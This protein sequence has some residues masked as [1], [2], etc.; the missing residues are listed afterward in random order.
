MDLADVL[1]T[2]EEAFPYIDKPARVQIPFHNDTCFHCE[3]ILKMLDEH[4]GRELPATAIACL[5]DDMSALSAKGTQWVLPSYLRIALRSKD[6]HDR[7]PEFLIYTLG[8]TEEYAQ[9]TRL[10]L[11]LLNTSQ[12]NCLLTVLLYWQG[13]PHWDEYC[14]QDLVNAITFIRNLISSEPLRTPN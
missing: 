6:P 7:I 2:V 8:Q 13:H 14:P 10:Q 9:E 11:A 4:P 3:A 12:L 5:C 1:K